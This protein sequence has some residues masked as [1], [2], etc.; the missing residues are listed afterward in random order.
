M[1][2]VYKRKIVWEFDYRFLFEE[3][4]KIVNK[5]KYIGVKLKKWGY[6]YL[7]FENICFK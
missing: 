6:G 3:K 5:C 4:F 1:I 7:F 2:I